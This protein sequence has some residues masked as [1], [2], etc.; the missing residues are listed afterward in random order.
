[1]SATTLFRKRKKPD[2]AVEEQIMY[3]KNSTTALKTGRTAQLQSERDAKT[4]RG[5]LATRGAPSHARASLRSAS[6][7]VR[8]NPF[9]TVATYLLSFA[10]LAG[11]SFLI[12]QI[13][14]NLA[15]VR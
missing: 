11:G 7:P 9:G 14:T 5:F 10:L 1:M 4:E 6:R 3:T 2:Q 12:A 15:M 13:W 8:A